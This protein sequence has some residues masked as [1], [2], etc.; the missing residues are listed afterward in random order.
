MSGGN[1]LQRLTMGT[2]QKNQTISDGG[3]A[4]DRISTAQQFMMSNTGN[5]KLIELFIAVPTLI[6][7]MAALVGAL[8]ENIARRRKIARRTAILVHLSKRLDL[9]ERM[10]ELE[11]KTAPGLARSILEKEALEH[12][13]LQAEDFESLNKLFHKT[14]WELI[15]KIASACALFLALWGAGATLVTTTTMTDD[16]TKTYVIT[17]MITGTALYLLMAYFFWRLSRRQKTTRKG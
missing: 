8:N 2:A 16:S 3:F 1:A 10:A 7:A 9:I 5:D 15:F 11:S 14:N 6:T 13:R 12:E 4:G 17:S